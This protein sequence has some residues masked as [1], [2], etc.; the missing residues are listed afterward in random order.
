MELPFCF[1][2]LEI[3]SFLV[4]YLFLNLFVGTMENDIIIMR[5]AESPD[6]QN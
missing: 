5:G 3:A 2:F 1:F 4:L 6:S